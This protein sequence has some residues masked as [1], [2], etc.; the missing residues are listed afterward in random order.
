MAVLVALVGWEA[1]GVIIPLLLFAVLAYGLLRFAQGPLSRLIARVRMSIRWKVLA[2]VGLMALLVTAVSVI[3]I[4][5]MDYMHTRLHSIQSLETS[6][7]DDVPAAVNALAGEQHGILG[8]TPL[9]GLLAAPIVLALGI[10]IAWSVI[11]PVRRMQEAMRRF[12]SGDFSEGV[13]V[14]NRDELGDLATSINDTARDLA[15]LQAAALAAERARALRE[16]IAQVTVAQEEERRRIS[17]EL[18]DG[19]AP[20]LAAMG[21]RLRVCQQLV[22]SDPQRAEG[23]LGEMASGLKQHIQEI[24]HLIYDLRPSTLDQLGLAEAL[25]QLLNRYRQESDVEVFFTS[26]GTENLTP[27]AEVTVLRVIQECLSN[28]EKHAE[29]SEVRVNVTL[30]DG[31]LEAVVQDNGNGFDYEATS[32]L[33]LGVGLL[34]MQ[35]RAGRVGGRIEVDTERGRGTNVVLRIPLTEANNGA[36]PHPVSR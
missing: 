13:T 32:A 12:A 1:F 18:H 23:E 28:V 3:N 27:L 16:R 6:R 29:A 34:S 35:E 4:G 17:R 20:S 19:L 8:S 7:P 5:A 33:G 9:F 24:R 21:N 2:I 14:E 15:T 30:T 10:A 36:N 25:K 22:R 11:G 26:S 31:E